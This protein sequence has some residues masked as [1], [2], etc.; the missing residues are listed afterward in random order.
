MWNLTPEP[1]NLQ[2]VRTSVVSITY[3]ISTGHKLRYLLL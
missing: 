2:V 3:A 1:L